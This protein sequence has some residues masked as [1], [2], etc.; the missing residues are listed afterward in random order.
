M[1]SWWLTYHL[2]WFAPHGVRGQIETAT[3]F[4]AYATFPNY[5][6]R[7]IQIFADGTVNIMPVHYREAWRSICWYVHSSL[8]TAHRFVIPFYVELK[9]IVACLQQAFKRLVSRNPGAKRKTQKVNT[10]SDGIRLNWQSTALLLQAIKPTVALASKKTKHLTCWHYV[11]S[12][13]LPMNRNHLWASIPNQSDQICENL[14]KLH[15]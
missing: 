12:W 8:Q 2:R 7:A 15:Y 4:L 14:L 5:Q 11:Q 6:H 13:Q 9:F 3:H 1:Q 10:T